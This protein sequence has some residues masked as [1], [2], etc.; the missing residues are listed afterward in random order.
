MPNI[1]ESITIDFS[2]LLLYIYAM[3]DYYELI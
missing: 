1:F 3:Q 2:G